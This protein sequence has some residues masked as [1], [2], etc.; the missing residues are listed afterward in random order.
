MWWD[1]GRRPSTSQ[2]QRRRSFP[3]A[4]EGTNPATLDFGLP[5]SGTARQ[6][7]YWSHSDCGIGYSSPRELIHLGIP[8]S[9]FHLNI[10]SLLSPVHFPLVQQWL[11]DQ[12]HSFLEHISSSGCQGVVPL[13]EN[14]C[15]KQKFPTGSSMIK[16]HLWAWEKYQSPQFHCPRSSQCHFWRFSCQSHSCL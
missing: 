11:L 6:Y 1:K 8:D 2:E 3:M 10:N 14:H 5:A 4:P 7:I 13:V 12:P 9:S 16:A 15:P